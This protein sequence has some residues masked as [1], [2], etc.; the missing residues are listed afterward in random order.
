MQNFLQNNK[1]FVS[2]V[3]LCDIFYSRFKRIF[4]LNVF[5]CNIDFSLKISNVPFFAVFL[6]SFISQKHIAY[7]QEKFGIS[8]VHF[9]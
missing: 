9:Y 1:F 7:S 2:V 6:C 4:G 5:F 3:T 8:H